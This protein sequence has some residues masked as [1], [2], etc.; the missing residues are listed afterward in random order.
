MRCADI[1]CCSFWCEEIVDFSDFSLDK[2][3]P[4]LSSIK[5]KSLCFCQRS[6]ISKNDCCSAFITSSLVFKPYIHRYSEPSFI[7][8]SLGWYFESNKSRGK[9]F[10]CKSTLKTGISL[11]SVLRILLVQSCIIASSLVRTFRTLVHHF[12]LW[13]ISVPD[14]WLFVSYYLKCTKVLL[15]PSPLF[16]TKAHQTSCSTKTVYWRSTA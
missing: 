14:P 15:A 1:F 13:V 4:A 2:V 12:V 7:Q 8:S 9:F 11:S 3:S 6:A 10:N 16:L 5:T